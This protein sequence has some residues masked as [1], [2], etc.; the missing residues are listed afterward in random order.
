[1]NA[2]RADF[3][4]SRAPRCAI[5]RY[6]SRVENEVQDGEAGVDESGGLLAEPKV[7]DN[8][9][10]KDSCVMKL[11]VGE[12]TVEKQGPVAQHKH[13]GAVQGDSVE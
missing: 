2:F 12:V 6:C 7:N 8:E 5:R 11:R 1:M 4:M 9:Q 3:I 10:R 13:Q